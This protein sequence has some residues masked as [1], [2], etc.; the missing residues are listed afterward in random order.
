LLAAKAKHDQENGKYV[1][2]EL[3]PL[4]ENGLVN[5][6]GVQSLLCW[7]F[8]IRWFLL[9]LLLLAQCFLRFG[10]LGIG[11]SQLLNQ[12]FLNPSTWHLA[13]SL[14]LP[15]FSRRFPKSSSMLTGNRCKL[16]VH[17]HSPMIHGFAPCVAS[18][19][20]PPGPNSLPV[21]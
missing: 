16:D 20:L 2:H 10:W 4:F 1:F 3:E 12:L 5:C 6:F 18:T 15:N 21:S 8:R 9:R 17:Q 14:S 11:I 7:W 13:S 19:L